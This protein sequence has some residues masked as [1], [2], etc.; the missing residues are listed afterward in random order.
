MESLSAQLVPTLISFFVVFAR[1]GSMIMLMPGLGEAPV[2]SRVRLAIAMA[3]C[4]L[5][6]PAIESQIPTETFSSSAFFT[7]LIREVILGLFLG[8]LLRL[9]LTCLNIA[10]GIIAYQGGLALA[11]GFDPTQGVQG[12]MMST[13]LTIMGLTI[14]FVADLHHLLIAALGDSYEIFP[15]GGPIPTRVLS[16][17]AIDTF[18]RSFVIGIQM[19]APFFAYGLIFY[20]G[21]GLLSR[22]MPQLQVFFVAV[23]LNILLGF[24]V[25]G[26]TLG[27]ILTLFTEYFEQT[28]GNFV[29]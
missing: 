2:P 27:A 25:L 21:I 29:R 23:P 6:Y 14:I 5:I 19:S 28:L 15:L 18:S 13:F 12:A 24:V 3:I 16:E 17:A 7:L 4:L 11:Q 1:V 8:A 26:I 10:G 20:A 9:M 22:L